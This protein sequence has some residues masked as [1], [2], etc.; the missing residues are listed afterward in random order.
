MFTEQTIKEL[1]ELVGI[2]LT[3]QLISARTINATL[4][5]KEADFTIPNNFTNRI[6]KKL[7][8]AYGCGIEH[9]VNLVKT[10]CDISLLNEQIQTL[11]GLGGSRPKPILDILIENHLI[12]KL[13]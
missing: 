5:P 8:K 12:N 13:W 2:D 9:A 4:K 1:I 11:N 10:S 3:Q 7:N 6:A